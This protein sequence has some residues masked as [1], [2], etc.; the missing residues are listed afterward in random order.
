MFMT[1]RGINRINI[2]K[3]FGSR[4]LNDYAKCMTKVA[5]EKRR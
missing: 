5:K 1:V 3:I 2:W 4:I